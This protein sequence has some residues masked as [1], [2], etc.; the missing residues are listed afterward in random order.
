MKNFFLGTLMLL[1][2]AMPGCGI[3][4]KQKPATSTP[5]ETAKMDQLIG[6]MGPP[7]DINI[8][9]LPTLTADTL[10]KAF[11]ENP[12]QAQL[13]YEKKWLKVQGVLAKGPLKFEIR[14]LSGYHLWIEHN[15]KQVACSFFGKI[16]EQQLAELKNGQSIVVVGRYGSDTSGP[17][18][19]FCSIVTETR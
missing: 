5:E 4:K 12:L 10:R 15:K 1:V 2:L 3:V 6:S 13:T 19:T 7:A 16:K 17:T 14:G 11:D 8:N 9:D 18:L